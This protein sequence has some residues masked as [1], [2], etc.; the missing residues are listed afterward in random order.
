MESEVYWDIIDAVR[1]LR[2]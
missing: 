1:T 2:D